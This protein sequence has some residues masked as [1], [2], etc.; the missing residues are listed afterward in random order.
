MFHN[1]NYSNNL[2]LCTFKVINMVNPKKMHAMCTAKKAQAKEKEEKEAKANEWRMCSD[3]KSEGRIYDSSNC[4]K[5]YKGKRSIY[6]SR[7]GLSK[8]L[9][10]PQNIKI[11]YDK[12]SSQAH[13]WKDQDLI[14]QAYSFLRTKYFT[15]Y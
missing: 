9:D 12:I 5:C 14:H 8:D 6:L 10:N 1:I 13:P 11:A 4:N 7:L 15:F 3:C 2:K